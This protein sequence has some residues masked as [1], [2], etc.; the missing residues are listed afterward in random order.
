V[1][2]TYSDYIVATSGGKPVRLLTLNRIGEADRGGGAGGSRCRRGTGL[3]DYTGREN[4][5][6]LSSRERLVVTCIDR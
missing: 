2:G 6:E 3:S 4:L 5:L 1:G